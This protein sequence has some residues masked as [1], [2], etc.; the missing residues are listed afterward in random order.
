[1]GSASLALGVLAL[2]G[3]LLTGPWHASASSSGKAP[4]APAFVSAAT[5]G[6]I[7][8]RLG[9]SRVESA[10]YVLTQRS[11]AAKLLGE[12]WVHSQPDPSVYLVIVRGDLAAPHSFVPAGW[13]DPVGK[14][15]AFTMDASTGSPLDFSIGDEPFDIAS[16]GPVGPVELASS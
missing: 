14:Y 5:K 12:G 8:A 4:P 9:A 10:E 1:M 2:M 11:S 6:L 7:Q 15:A 16:L 3:L 13:P